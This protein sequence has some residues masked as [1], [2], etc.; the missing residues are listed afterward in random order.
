MNKSFYSKEEKTNVKKENH[1][2]KQ[3]INIKQ[4]LILFRN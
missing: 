3:V 4:I 2:F 1:I